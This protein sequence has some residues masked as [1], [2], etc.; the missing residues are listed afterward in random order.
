MRLTGLGLAFAGICVVFLGRPDPSLAPNPALGNS[1]M[2]IAAVTA[3]VR[4][5]YTQRLVQWIEPTKTV[6]WQTLL[7]LPCF[8]LGT[9]FEPEVARG[10]LTWVPVAGVLYQGLAVGAAGLILWAY[11]LRK[12]SPGALSVFSFSIPIFGILLSAWLLS[13]QLTPRLFFGVAAVLTGIYLASR[14][15]PPQEAQIPE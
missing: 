4:T 9:F 11:L 5:V 7:S 2:L 13:E 10:P 12:H 6:Y 15:S 1:L 3:A 8:L 14:T